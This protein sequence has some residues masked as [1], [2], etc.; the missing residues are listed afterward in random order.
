MWWDRAG[1]IVSERILLD[2]WVLARFFWKFSNAE[3]KV[4]GPDPTVTPFKFTKD[5]TK[6]LLFNFTLQLTPVLSRWKM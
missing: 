1:V 5:L 6:E 4:R 2:T 3:A